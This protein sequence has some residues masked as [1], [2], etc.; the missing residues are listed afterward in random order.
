MPCPAT[1]ADIPGASIEVSANSERRRVTLMAKGD[2]D[3][4]A[5]SAGRRGAQAGIPPA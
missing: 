3:G 1:P 2:A 5:G 4:G